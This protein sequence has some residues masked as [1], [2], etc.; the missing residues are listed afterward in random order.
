MKI[1]TVG[2][3]FIVDTFIEAV[4]KTGKAEIAACYSRQPETAA[5]FAKKHGV[6]KLYT[7]RDAF[8]Q[9]GD[10]DCVYVAAPNALHYGWARDALTAGRSVICEKPFVSNAAELEDLAALAKEKRL[11]LFEALTVPHL[12]N[13]RLIREKLSA[14][15]AVRF[16]QL[17][18]SQYSSRYGAFLAGKNPN[19]FSPDF[20][21]GALMDLNYYNLCFILRLFGE[22]EELRYF[23]NKA[24]NGIDLSGLLVLRYG[25]FIA[26]AAATKDS[27]SSNF[28]QIQ[29]EKGYIVSRST[30]SNLRGGFD[31]VTRAAG[32]APGEE[33]FNA[34]ESENVLVY[35]VE[36]FIREYTAGDPSSSR[37][38]LTDSIIAARWMDRARKDAG[39]V[40]AA[41][42][43]T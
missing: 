11:F 22:P 15:G 25:G 23:A 41:D 5:A 3:N 19:L 39:I 16:V 42:K 24:E 37:E 4:R 10:L 13:F 14:V 40:F 12:P 28:V 27:D 38:A 20:S 34:Q 6:P 30:A 21:G 43:R 1:G 17:N 35:E 7:G 26:S 29:G 18:F 8:L 2:T 36:D 33:H 31:L 9:D 32:A